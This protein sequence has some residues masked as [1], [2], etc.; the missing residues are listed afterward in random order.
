MLC[1]VTNQYSEETNIVHLWMYMDIIVHIINTNRYKKNIAIT[2]C[3]KKTKIIRSDTQ[4]YKNINEMK[5]V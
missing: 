5:I 4:N 3:I 2:F 1:S